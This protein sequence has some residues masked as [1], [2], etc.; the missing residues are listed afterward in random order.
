M[1]SGLVGVGFLTAIFN[2][3]KGETGWFC[4]EPQ[5]KKGFQIIKLIDIFRPLKI[6]GSGNKLKK[7]N[8]STIS[9]FGS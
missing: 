1:Q 6:H 8:N 9:T 3:K 5:M 7:T 2:F 4:W